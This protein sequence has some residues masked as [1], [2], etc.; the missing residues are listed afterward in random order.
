MICP[1]FAWSSPSETGG[2][3]ECRVRASP[4]ARL[5]QKK[6]AAVTTG[7]A[8]SSGIPCAMVL[9]LIRVLPGVPG[10]LATVA[11]RNVSQSLTPASGGQ[12]HTTSPSAPVLRQLHRKR[13]SHPAANTRDDREA[14]LSRRRDG[15]ETTID[16][17]K[18]EE[19]YFARRGL[20]SFRNRRSDLPG[21]AKSVVRFDTLKR[22]AAIQSVRLAA[23]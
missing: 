12:D 17:R 10:F 9:R 22:C 2:R 13:P 19:D 4:M 23:A 1:S 11:L 16:F 8:G 7:S 15:D 21:R 20:T 14:P 6:Q 18:T 5:Q 3:R